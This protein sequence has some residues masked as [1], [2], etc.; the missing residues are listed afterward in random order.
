MV[1]FYYIKTSLLWS[2]CVTFI[3]FVWSGVVPLA[4]SKMALEVV[5]LRS[6]STRVT[7]TFWGWGSPGCNEL[8]SSTL[9]EEGSKSGGDSSNVL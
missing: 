7:I 9:V 3:N 5:F 6:G 2:A 8:A 1:V 4:I